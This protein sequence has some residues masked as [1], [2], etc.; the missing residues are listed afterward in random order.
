MS[1]IAG[2]TDIPA[3]APHFLA[4]EV[5]RTLDDDAGEIAPRVR[6]SVVPSI[7]PCTFFT[8]LGFERRRLDLHEHLPRRGLG[9]GEILHLQS[10]QIT[11]AMEAQGSQRLASIERAS[12][13]W[14]QRWM[15][16]SSACSRAWVG[17][18][19]R[20]LDFGACCSQSRPRVPGALARGT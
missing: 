8:S 14:S 2:E 15:G 11:E 5:C 10:A 6:G 19:Q 12:I 7:F 1:A 16:A 4:H 20:V 17:A 9:S 13:G 3:G 18:S